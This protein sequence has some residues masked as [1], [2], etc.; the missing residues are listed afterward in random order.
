MSFEQTSRYDPFSLSTIL[1]TT[2]DSVNSTLLHSYLSDNHNNS[3]TSSNNNDMG[4]N[5][6]VPS[7]RENEF[8]QDSR[9][10]V[11]DEQTSNTQDD[12]E[13]IISD[14]A[15]TVSSRTTNTNPAEHDSPIGYY[16]SRSSLSHIHQ[17]SIPANNSAS[18][19][20]HSPGNAPG[21]HILDRLSEHKN[22]VLSL[23][24]EVPVSASPRESSPL[25]H[26]FTNEDQASNLSVVQRPSPTGSLH[27]NTPSTVSS[28][29]VTVIQRWPSPSL[30]AEKSFASLDDTAPPYDGYPFIYGNAKKMP[31]RVRSSP[32][33]SQSP[34]RFPMS[35]PRYR[36]SRSD[37][38]PSRSIQESNDIFD[39]D[40]I[41]W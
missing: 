33:G 5:I 38:S 19:I 25:R 12:G 2:T 26:S 11:T 30:L 18:S 1:L 3:N 9:E 21:G 24:S 8:Q 15:A 16:Q 14:S 6:S 22:E 13:S 17:D 39:V 36:E 32:I 40:D 37:A 4:Q 41:K 23:A 7:L 31:I 29:P 27:Q 28:R 34:P 20:D 10:V 35:P